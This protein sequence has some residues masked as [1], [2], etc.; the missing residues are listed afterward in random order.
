[1]SES[2]E[3]A[4]HPRLIA[5]RA[6][7]MHDGSGGQDQAR[8]SVFGEPGQ[9]VIPDLVFDQSRTHIKPPGKLIHIVGGHHAADLRAQGRSRRKQFGC[10]GARRALIPSVGARYQTRNCRMYAVA[11][12]IDRAGETETICPIP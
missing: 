12:E 3:A 7:R 10:E 4:Q 5:V 1:M 2:A 11:Q 8:R 6:D 9:A